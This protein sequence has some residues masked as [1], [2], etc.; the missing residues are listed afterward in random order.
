MVV[1]ADCISTNNI[2]T[3]RLLSETFDPL[4]I[5]SVTII[6][7]AQINMILGG[8]NMTSLSFKTAV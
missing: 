6:Q 5:V 8:I 7:P 4:M 1:A 2:S 3:N